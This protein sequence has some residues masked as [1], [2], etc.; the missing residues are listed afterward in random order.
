M[1]VSGYSRQDLALTDVIEGATRGEALVDERHRPNGDTTANLEFIG[2]DAAVRAE[3]H[4]VTD[5]QRVARQAQRLDTHR[6]V[7][8][9][10]EIPA[11]RRVASD[12]HSRQVGNSE[13]GAD[14]R[15]NA[16]VYGIATVQ[17]AR[18]RNA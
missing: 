15:S 13:T 3:A 10:E 2:D 9:N 16:D 1:A 11:D 5:H 7:L 4:I 17:F 14:L 12:D 18:M 8:P 6:G